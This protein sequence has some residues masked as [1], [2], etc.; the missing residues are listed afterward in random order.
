MRLRIE[1]EVASFVSTHYKVTDLAGRLVGI[2]QIQLI[3]VYGIWQLDPLSPGI[4]VFCK[5]HSYF[6]DYKLRFV[7]VHIADID[8]QVQIG[9]QGGG[10]ALIIGLYADLK[11]GLKYIT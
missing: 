6:V 9:A 8:S 10:Q 1:M 5:V 7:I 2:I 3:L 11:S 4:R